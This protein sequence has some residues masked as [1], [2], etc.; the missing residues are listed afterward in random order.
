MQAEWGKYAEFFSKYSENPNLDCKKFVFPKVVSLINVKNKSLL[1]F[2]CGVGT[3]ARMFRS[4][5]AR[6]AAYDLATNM[7]KTAIST[8][9]NMGIKYF[10]RLNDIQ[11]VFD[12]IFCQMVLVANNKNM[13][14]LAVEQIAQLLKEGRIGIFVNVNHRKIGKKFK[15]FYSILPEEKTIGAPYKTLVCIDEKWLT[16]TD[17]YYTDQYFQEMFLKYNLKEIH[18]E[19]IKE[20]YLLQI[21]RKIEKNGI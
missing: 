15:D 20:Q 8:G 5:G 1:D 16:F 12:I 6:V 7:V 13:M 9:Q 10:Y 17:Y 14:E 4:R 18:R 3:Y 2:G 19:V 11:T 21:V